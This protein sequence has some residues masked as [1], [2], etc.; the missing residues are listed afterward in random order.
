MQFV[1]QDTQVLVPVPLTMGSEHDL[2][3]LK[4]VIIDM[5]PS[6]VRNLCGHHGGGT[7]QQQT[8]YREQK[9]AATVFRIHPM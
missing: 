6:V 7:Q 1:L 3:H 5:P 9:T 8:T 4:D 2:Q